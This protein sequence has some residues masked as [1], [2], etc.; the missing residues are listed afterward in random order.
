MGESGEQVELIGQLCRHIESNLE[1][2]LRLADL[3]LRA[4]LS[5][6]HLQ[7]T[8]KRITGITPRQYADACRLGRLKERLRESDT[9][10]TAMYEA[11]YSSSSRLYERAASQLGMTPATYRRGGPA[12]LIRFTLTDCPLGRLLVAGTDRGVCAV[13]LGDGDAYLEGVLR[14]EYPAASLER[15]DERLRAW[16]AALV[17]HLRGQRP[18]LDLPLDVQ[19]T[20]FQW[21]VW[22]ELC[23]IPY[24]ETASYREVARRIGKPTAARAVARACATN[25]VAVIVPCHR[26]VRED[27]GLGGYRWGIGRK[28]VL[29]AQ[30]QASASPERQRRVK[31]NGRSAGQ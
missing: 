2:P 6:A 29:L 20:A 19:A 18:H 14:L 24:G 5:P 13:S 31:E 10:T 17:E 28:R 30:E 1:S 16:A 22:Q 25:P 8:F 4:G 23:A 21:R 9:V 11:G 27:G 15:D 12:T 26:V 7:R 3:A